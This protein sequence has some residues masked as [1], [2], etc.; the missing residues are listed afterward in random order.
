MPGADGSAR[1]W[2]YMSCVARSQPPRGSAGAGRCG[3]S[4]QAGD[5]APQQAP[6]PAR[7]G[8]SPAAMWTAR[9]QRCPGEPHSGLAAPGCCRLPSIGREQPSASAGPALAASTAAAARP[10]PPMRYEATPSRASIAAAG[11]VLVTSAGSDAAAVERTSRPRRAPR[12]C[13]S[14]QMTPPRAASRAC[15]AASSAAASSRGL[16]GQP[17]HCGAPRRRRVA[18]AAS[19]RRRL[20]PPAAR[21]SG[22]CV[23]V[24]PLGRRS[25]RAPPRTGSRLR[26]GARCARSG[27]VTAAARRSWPAV[28]RA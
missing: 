1:S 23:P 21:G 19:H 26:I 25:P 28:R 27:R 18:A 10:V 3:L 4:T 14:A 16:R 9:Q 7:L 13:S 22:A 17:R 12:S 11:A 15:G 6:S 5:A 8:R 2:P 24:E 20:T